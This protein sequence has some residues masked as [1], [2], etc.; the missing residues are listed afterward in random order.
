[1]SRKRMWKRSFLILVGL[2]SL[3]LA[4]PQPPLWSANLSTDY[5]GVP[6]Y[7]S[8]VATP[9][10]LMLM[11]NSLSMRARANCDDTG[12][13]QLADGTVDNANEWAD[14]FNPSAS[15]SG[16]FDSMR[17]YTYRNGTWNNDVNDA[18]NRFYPQ[19]TKNPA[20]LIGACP[21]DQWDGNLL[22]WITF[23]RIDAIKKA[24]TGGECAGLLRNNDGTCPTG[25]D[26]KITIQS[27]RSDNLLAE[28][29]TLSTTNPIG[30]QITGRIPF[31]YRFGATTLAIHLRGTGVYGGWFCVNDNYDGLVGWYDQNST[32]DAAA[33]TTGTAHYHQDPTPAYDVAPYDVAPYDYTAYNCIETDCQPYTVHVDGYHVN[34]YH[35]D[36]QA[37]ID[38]DYPITCTCPGG[39]P[40]AAGFNI[41]LAFDVQPRGVI[42]QVGSQARLGLMVFQAPKTGIDGGIVTV[43]IGSQQSTVVSTPRTN[44]AAAMIDGMDAIIAQTATPLAES[45]YEAA[46][47]VAQL[48]PTYDS[49][50]YSY[51]YAFA[52]AASFKGVGVGSIGPNEI[53]ALAAGETC[54]GG[55]VADTCGRDP[56]FFGQNHTPAWASP[57]ALVNCC[58]TFVII[59]TDG[60]PTVDENIPNALKDYALNKGV[61]GKTCTGSDK[62]AT[63]DADG[64]CN[65]KKNTSAST[66]LHER[67]TDFPSAGHYLD[68]VAL[69][70]HTTDLRQSTIPVIN[71]PGHDLPGMQNLTLYTVYAFGSVNGREILM[72][73]S[74]QGG[75][76]D[77]PDASNLKNG[78]PD[79]GAVGTLPAIGTN[80][81]D[82][83][84]ADGS[85][86]KS[87]PEWD[88]VNNV[89]G[90]GGPDC[91]PDNY[92]ES[93]NA[94]EIRDRLLA[95][96]KK[97]TEVNTSGASASVLA[98]ASTGEGITY[99]AFFFQNKADATWLGYL[100]GFFVDQFGNLREDTK[101]DGKLVLKDDYVIKLRFDD[102][103]IPP[104]TVA[105]RFKDTQGNGMGDMKVD[106]VELSDLVPVW[107]AGRRLAFTDT[108]TDCDGSSTWPKSGNLSASGVSC[109]RILTW[110]DKDNNGI[111]DV[112]ERVE[113]TT[114]NQAA[115]CPF[116]GGKDVSTCGGGPG[117]TEAQNIINW[118]RG[119]QVTGLRDRKLDVPDNS[120]KPISSIW[121]LGDI[122]SSTPT[123]VGAPRE[124]YDIIYGDSDYAQFYQRYKDRRQVVYAGANDGMLHAFN[125]G[126]LSAGVATKN[127]RIR[128]TTQ[129]LKPGTED[130][131]GTLPCDAPAGV[132]PY[133]VR[134]PVP[135]GSEVWAFIP[136]DLLP[137]LQWLTAQNYSHT[138]YVDLKPKITDARIFPVDDDHPGGWGTILI[139]GMRFGGSCSNC[140][141]VKGSART[142]TADFN[143][144]GTSTRVFLSSYF[145]LD[146][147]NPEKD[148][149]LLWTFR[150]QD[151]G[152]TTAAPAVI[153]VNTESGAGPGISSAGEKWYAVFGTG[154]THYDGSSGQTAQVFVVDLKAGPSYIS[155]NQTSG[156]VGTQNCAASPCIAANIDGVRVGVFSTKQKGFM[157]DTVSLDADLDFRV[158]VIYVGSVLCN[159]LS[160]VNSPCNG[161]NPTWKGTMWR[162]T[163]DHGQTNLN[164]WG[165]GGAPTSVISAFTC[166]G[167]TC[168]VGPVP[169]ASALSMDDKDNF[170]V[171]FG[172]GRLIA[173]LDST[174]KDG[175]NFFG[176]KDCIASNKCTD[177][178]IE[179]NKL[180]DVSDVEICAT[181]PDGVTN[182]C[183]A[184]TVSTDQG[185]SFTKGFDQFVSSIQDDQSK[186]GWFTTL[187]AL[188][189]R[190]LS[191]PTLLGGTLFFTTFSPD[192]S[193]CE[194]NGGSRLYG[195]FFV[196]G[197]AFK[198]SML[199]DRS[200]L[201]GTLV[202]NRSVSIEPGMPSQVALHLGAQGT[203]ASGTTSSTGCSGRVTASVLTSNNAI[204][205]TCGRPALR[206]WSAIIAWRDM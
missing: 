116:L 204:G 113:F 1:M 147:T 8:S 104:H 181:P 28:F 72:Q 46:R 11:D 22:N 27:H 109:R 73:A 47:Y 45:L 91:I 102:T 48:P 193:V 206:P 132:T 198:T 163:T 166:K 40:T 17:C 97:I 171:F 201:G 14:T 129:P 105:D 115:L 63:H 26:G 131:C 138:Y 122:M 111:V 98:S 36:A 153:R 139:G 185:N 2:G 101:G 6:P 68:D 191:M 172:T 160:T 43:G 203:G 51:P 195:L 75:F 30:D 15:Y 197:T 89:T 152:L 70:V 37:A 183:T 44:N 150:D 39:D 106:T 154:M 119:N 144:T 16:Y 176:V 134:T 120:G 53:K 81:Q 55:Y 141:Q 180:V 165:I 127:E 9:N 60:A 74:R 95:T 5:T 79:V 178:K 90:K 61:S 99:Q 123:S 3:M 85:T 118:I 21:A 128:F 31:A 175:Q 145:V 202:S 59:V 20:T 169:A 54:P 71:Q 92:F 42:Q 133:D 103:L 114:T 124:R 107:E 18:D 148:P 80:L 159:T 125:G 41:R 57:S 158:D 151:L 96:I 136:Q 137:Q 170:W 13:P 161:S 23:R 162:L 100:Q 177:Q 140:N 10:I 184:T 77:K 135:L 200:I 49:S 189:E 196:S 35:V 94:D 33:V 117:Q 38:Y 108:G 157:G 146:I 65:G 194:F 88:L 58:Q 179:R 32:C 62:N 190:S 12:C 182:T 78:L 149:V 130:P 67:K 52:G 110:I 186:D 174:N 86:G 167:V 69:W 168:S 142:V 76:V 24:M 156:T 121:K 173:N 192:D 64:T 187:P 29:M 87:S 82:C 66:L 56:Y 93:S 155:M 19:N 205:Q 164:T 83:T 199:G 50:G 34:G 7:V 84:N 188:R 126:F 112:G 4:G 25:G 143:G